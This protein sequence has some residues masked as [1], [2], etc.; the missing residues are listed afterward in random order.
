MKERKKTRFPLTLT[1]TSG[2]HRKRGLRHNW[3]TQAITEGTSGKAITQ[4]K[5]PDL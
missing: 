5:L 3:L 4:P 1:F 2:I